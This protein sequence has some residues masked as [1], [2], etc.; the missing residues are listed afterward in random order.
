MRI[1]ARK[2]TAI[3]LCFILLFN[4]SQPAACAEERKVSED[5]SAMEQE[6]ESMEIDYAPESFPEEASD[7]ND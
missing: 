7:P 3:F 5:Y 2:L 4:L 1:S 6:M